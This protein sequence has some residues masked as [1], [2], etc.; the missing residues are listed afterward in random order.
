MTRALLLSGGMDSTALAF[1][2]RPE[3]AITIDYG[4]LP[5]AA[6]IRASEAVCSALKIEH[7]IITA[8]LNAL[9][10]GDLSGQAPLDSAPA[11]EWWPFR[12]Q[13]LITLAAMACAGKNISSLAIGALVTDGFHSDGTEEFVNAMSHLLGVQEGALQL[14]APAIQMT[15]AELVL[16]SGI[17][18]DILAWSH[19]CH[20]SE[21]ACGFCR[22]CRKHYETYAELG[23]APY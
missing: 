2:L 12:N 11:S 3:L 19:S 18:A 9:G 13:M 21:F 8:D 1:S 17:P 20:V 16:T 7:L 23:L 10:S 22:G 14:E 15:A 6:E 5:A 4:Q